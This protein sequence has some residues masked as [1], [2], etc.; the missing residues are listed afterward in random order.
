MRKSLPIAVLVLLFALLAMV[1]WISNRL[2]FKV[3]DRAKPRVQSEIKPIPPQG[4][5]ASES[6]LAGYG[7]LET[8]PIEDLRKIHRVT[9]GYFSLIKDSGRFAIGGNAD[10]SAALQGENP[11]RQV[12]IHRDHP[13][14]SAEGLLLDRWGSPLVVHPEGWRQLELRSS[15]P[16]RIAHTEDDIILSPS[17]VSKSD[18]AGR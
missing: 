16:D 3:P 2:D 18:G 17:G 9:M 14:F 11:N 5:T 12:F 13:I 4:A 8:P 1:V 7:D 6:L 10:F 15:G